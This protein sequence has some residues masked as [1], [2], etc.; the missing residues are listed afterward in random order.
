MTVRP[1][2]KLKKAILGFI[3]IVLFFCPFHVIAANKTV[4]LLP[5]Q[6]FADPSKAYLGQGIKTMLAS[7]LSGKDWR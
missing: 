1:V 5:L 4:A 7:R 2:R 6:L 3:V